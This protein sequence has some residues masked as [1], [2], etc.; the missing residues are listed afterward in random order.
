MINWNEICDMM[1]FGAFSPGSQ[2]TGEIERKT[3][4]AIDS[5]EEY[6]QSVEYS[7]G[8]YV[9]RY[10]EKNDYAI[11]EVNGFSTVSTLIDKEKLQRIMDE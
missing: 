4:L 6:H 9:T 3:R 8:F 2:I 10:V 7:Y 5:A 11:C 1:E